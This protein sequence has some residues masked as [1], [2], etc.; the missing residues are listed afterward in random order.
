MDHFFKNSSLLCKYT[1]HCLDDSEEHEIPSA[2]PTAK[3][4]IAL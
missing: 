1:L 4:E 3:K 2:A